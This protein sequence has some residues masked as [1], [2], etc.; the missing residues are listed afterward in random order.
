ML[1]KKLAVLVAAAMM[2]L[3]AV[4]PALAAAGGNPP[5]GTCGLSKDLVQ[6]AISDE[7]PKKPSPPGASEEGT[8]SPEACKGNSGTE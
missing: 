1:R 3:M 8:V 7:K 4:S 2:L 6:D 5:E